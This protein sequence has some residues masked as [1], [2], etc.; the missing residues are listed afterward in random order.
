MRRYGVLS[1][2]STDNGGQFTGRYVKP[3]PVEAMFERICRENGIKQ[4][5]TKPGSTTTTGKV[6]RLH[7]T[8][9]FRS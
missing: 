2:V 9:W 5:L 6:E 7:R 3:Q 1:E 8:K 4:R